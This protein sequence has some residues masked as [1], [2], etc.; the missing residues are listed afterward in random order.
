MER[1]KVEIPGI[2]DVEFDIGAESIAD[3]DKK[4]TEIKAKYTGKTAG[5][6]VVG[7]RQKLTKGQLEGT[8]LQPAS[9]PGPRGTPQ[10]TG[11]PAGY[12]PETSSGGLIAP[13]GIGV[14]GRTRPSMGA[15]AP[16][17][18]PAPRP[19]A[20]PRA[21]PFISSTGVERVEPQEMPELTQGQNVV[22][23]RR[24][25]GMGPAGRPEYTGKPAGYEP[26]TRGE[27][28]RDVDVDLGETAPEEPLPTVSAGAS[29]F[30]ASSAVDREI[31]VQNKAKAAGLGKYSVQTTTPDGRVIKTPQDMGQRT[32]ILPGGRRVVMD[33]PE[34][35]FP[36]REPDDQPWNFYGS[37]TGIPGG[38]VT[39]MEH[40]TF[41]DDQ[42]GF[43]EAA[44]LVTARG[45]AGIAKSMG[46]MPK[47]GAQIQDE[48]ARGAANVVGAVMGDTP[49]EAAARQQSFVEG[50]GTARRWL[51]PQHALLQAAG[52]KLASGAGQ[53]QDVLSQQPA[54]ELMDRTTRDMSLGQTITNPQA[55][56]MMAAEN[57]P[58]LAASYAAAT[59]A[60]AAAPMFMFGLEAGG[61]MDELD[62]ARA[63]G[64]DIPEQKYV[65]SAVGT[66]VVNMF[67]ENLGIK[68]VQGRLLKEHPALAAKIGKFAESFAGKSAEAILGEG[69]TEGLQEWTNML[70]SFFASEP[71]P[72]IDKV[73][74]FLSDSKNWERAGKAAAAGS[75]LGGMV[76][77]PRLAGDAIR[78]GK[79]AAKK[80][81][82]EAA[83]ARGVAPPE[84]T[85]E[86]AAEVTSAIGE[87]MA[88]Q[89]AQAPPVEEEPAAPAPPP[90]PG[91]EA[92]PAPE[93]AQDF[94]TPAAPPVAEEPVAPPPGQPERRTDEA[95]A[96]RVSELM[97]KRGNGDISPEE[98]DEL[99]GLLHGR[100][101]SEAR[102][103][104]VASKEAR[105]HPISDLPNVRAF[106]EAVKA[107][108][109]TG[110]VATD[111]RGFKA[112]NDKHGQGAGNQI[113]RQAAKVM[114]DFAKQWG[115]EAYGIGG[116][117]VTIGLSGGTDRAAF[118]EA[119]EGHLADQGI[120]VVGQDGRT[121][122]YRGI[123]IKLLGGDDATVND[124]LKTEGRSTALSW[125]VEEEARTGAPDAGDVAG[126]APPVAGGTGAHPGDVGGGTP[127]VPAEEEVAPA[128]PKVYSAD[129]SDTERD[130]VEEAVGKSGADAPRLRGGILEGQSG[131]GWQAVLDALKGKADTLPGK[132]GR[133]AAK[134]RKKLMEAYGAGPV[135]ARQVE[136]APAAAPPE[137][138]AA[139]YGTPASPNV[140]AI[141]DALVAKHKKGIKFRLRKA[142]IAEV[143][144]LVGGKI[145]TSTP[146]IRAVDE[147]VELARV[148]R[149]REVFQE[150][151]NAGDS[152][153]AILEK[154]NR[155][156]EDFPASEAR[157]SESKAGQEFSTPTPLAFVVSRLAG[158]TSDS[159]VLDNSAGNGAMFVAT[160][161]NHA[162][163]V[164]LSETRAEHLRSQGIAVNEGDGRSTT[165]PPYPAG[166]ETD[167]VLINPP[168]GAAEQK[169]QKL[170]YELALAAVE[171][172]KVGGTLGLIV[173]GPHPS[174]LGNDDARAAHYK[175]L[176]TQGL[177][178]QLA[179][180]GVKVERVFTVSGKIYERSGTTY[181]VDVIVGRKMDGP[182]E[183]W[184]AFLNLPPVVKTEKELADVLRVKT[185]GATW[186]RPGDI[187]RPRAGFGE[188]PSDKAVPPPSD[189]DDGR[190]GGKGPADR[191]G[192]DR[193]AGPGDRGGRGGED[194]GGVGRGPERQSGEGDLAGAGPRVGGVNPP[195]GPRDG[196]DAGQGPAGSQPDVRGE[197]SRGE[198]ERE[199]PGAGGLGPADT[200]RPGPGVRG[201]LDPEA[202]RRIKE[203]LSKK[204][205][206]GLPIRRGRGAVGLPAMD[207]SA[208]L[209]AVNNLVEVAGILQSQ[210][211]GVSFEE[212]ISALREF[213]VDPDVA[214]FAAV[215]YADAYDAATPEQQAQMTDPDTGMEEWTGEK[216]R[217]F[218][219]EKPAAPEQKPEE[220][221]SER[222]KKEVTV[223]KETQEE[224][225]I[226]LQTPNTPTSKR[227]SIGSL[228]PKSLAEATANALKAV[229]EAHGPI[230][231]FVREELGFSKEEFYDKG[232]LS[233]EQVDALGLAL[234]QFKQGRGFILADQ[235]GIGKGRVV[236][237]ILVWA[238]K[239][240]NLPMFLTEKSKLYADM[241]RDLKAIGFPQHEPLITDNN[242]DVEIDPASKRKFI[243]NGSEHQA[244]LAEAVQNYVEK[245]K[246]KGKTGAGASTL[247][248]SLFSTYN[249]ITGPSGS[250]RFQMLEQVAFGSVVVL[251]ES[252][253][254][255]GGN[256]A[257]AQSQQ[258]GK[259]GKGTPEHRG[260]RIAAIIG[261]AKAVLFSSA[262]FA[263]R[264]DSLI[265]YA[266]FTDAGRMKMNPQELADTIADGGVPLQQALSHMLVE[267]GQMIRREKSFAG[268][269]F[270]VEVA[271]ADKETSERISQAT[272]DLYDID[273]MMDEY[274]KGINAE[275]AGETGRQGGVG[276]KQADRTVFSSLFNNLIGQ[277]L[278]ALKV[279]IVVAKIKAIHDAGDSPFVTFSSTMEFLL[280]E[281]PAAAKVDSDEDT[282]V[283]I[284][285]ADNLKRY[286]Q[287]IITIRTK[288]AIPGG[289]PDLHTLTDDELEEIDPALLAAVEAIRKQLATDEVLLSIPGSPL[290]AVRYELE[291]YGLKVAEATGR[292]SK[293]EYDSDDYRS[294]RIVSRAAEKTVQAQIDMVAGY[295][296]RKGKVGERHV[297]KVDVIIANQSASTGIS[298]HN[299]PDTG[300]NRRRRHMVIVSPE[301]NI[302]TYMQMLGRINRTG[303]LTDPESLPTY[304]LF[305]SDLPLEVRQAAVL[306][307]KMA[308]LSANTTGSRTNV[309]S[310]K[311]PD[312][313]NQVG[314]GVMMDLL[315]ERQDINRKLGKPLKPPQQGQ[316]PSSKGLAAKATARVILLPVNEQAEF[317]D[318]LKERYEARIEELDNAGENPLVAK[319]IDLQAE[320]V[321]SAEVDPKEEGFSGPFAESVRIGVYKTLDEFK[322]LTDEEL[323]GQ[324]RETLASTEPEPPKLGETTE[325]PVRLPKEAKLKT[326]EQL[327]NELVDAFDK[328]LEKRKAELEDN[329]RKGAKE[330]AAPEE[331]ADRIATQL[332]DADLKAATMRTLLRQRR[333]GD[334]LSVSVGGQQASGVITKVEYKNK[335]ANP[336][337]ASN[338]RYSIALTDMH[339]VLHVSAASLGSTNSKTVLTNLGGANHKTGEAAIEA[340]VKFMKDRHTGITRRTRVIF[341]GNVMK[342]YARAK[343]AHGHM[344]R[345]TMKD[346]TTR[347]GVL[348]PRNFDPNKY[349]DDAPVILT[350]VN[351][352]IEW[353]RRSGKPLTSL[354]DATPLSD[355]RIKN[356]W[357][358]YVLSASR[359]GT[360]T[361]S[362]VLTALRLA[363]GDPSAG[364]VK[365]T[366]GGRSE[367]N[368]GK[369]ENVKAFLEALATSGLSVRYEITEMKAL[370]REIAGMPPIET[371]QRE[372]PTII[373][374]KEI[375]EFAEVVAEFAKGG[376]SLSEYQAT[377]SL[378]DPEVGGEPGLLNGITFSLRSNTRTTGTNKAAIVFLEPRPAQLEILKAIPGATELPS[379]WGSKNVMLPIEDVKAW[380][381]SYFE[382]RI[383][384]KY[385]PEAHGSTPSLKLEFE[386]SS[387]QALRR[388]M[389]NQD[390]GGV[391]GLA[392]KAKG[393]TSTGGT[394]GPLSP[395][396][397]RSQRLGGPSN[398]PKL[399][400]TDDTLTPDEQRTAPTRKQEILKRIQIMA[401]NPIRAGLGAFKRRKSLGWYMPRESQFRMAT[402]QKT[403]KGW[404]AV[405]G[406][407]GAL[408]V[409]DIMNM[410]VAAHEAGHSFHDRF[411]EGG[412]LTA[413]N[414]SIPQKVAA[415]L[416]ALGLECYGSAGLALK[417]DRLAAEG[418]AELFSRNL[419]GM[420]TNA[421]PVATDWFFN[422]VLGPR[423]EMEVIY[424]ETAELIRQY[425]EQGSFNRV[426]AHIDLKPRTIQQ[427]LQKELK[428]LHELV[429]IVIDK[430]FSGV[431]KHFVDDAHYLNKMIEDILAMSG[432]Q[433]R[434]LLIS[435]DPYRLRQA[436]EMVAPAM[437]QYAVETA[438]IGIDGTERSKGLK[439]ILKEIEEKYDLT[440]FMVYAVA[441]RA[442]LLHA[443][444]MQSGLS[445][446][447]IH[448]VISNV[449]AQ[450]P[451]KTKA[452][453]DAVVGVTEWSNAIMFQ[454]VEAG[455]MSQEAYDKILLFNPVYVPFK[456]VFDAEIGNYRRGGT[457]SGGRGIV[458]R[459]S[460]VK[461][462]HGS[463]K[464][465]RDPMNEFIRG[466]EQMLEFR[467]QCLIAQAALRFAEKV[468]WAAR[469]IQ[470]VTKME[471]KARFPLEDIKGALKEAGATKE[472][473]DNLD[474]DT[475][476]ELWAPATWNRDKTRNVFR[477]YVKGKPKLFEI[478]DSVADV[479]NGAV[480]SGGEK[481]LG[482]YHA[483][484]IKKVFAKSVRM[485]ATA[486]S[487]SF[488][489]RN[490]FRDAFNASVATQWGPKR[491]NDMLKLLDV[492]FSMHAEGAYHMLKN[493]QYGAMYKAF[494]GGMSTLQ[495]SN[496]AVL[497][498]YTR[499]AFKF[500]R[501]KKEAMAERALHPL[502][503]AGMG[504]DVVSDVLGVFESMP[505]VAE[506]RKAFQAAKDRN[507]NDR[508]AYLEALL[509]SKD[510]TTNFTRM[511]VTSRA[512]NQYIPFFNARI[513]GADKFLRMFRDDPT[514]FN[515]NFKR[516]ALMS[517]LRLTAIGIVFWWFN[518]D[519]DEYQRL[520]AYE[521]DRFWIFP[522][523][524]FGRT[525]KIP[526]PDTLGAA[527][528]T[529][530]EKILDA[531]Y[532]TGDPEVQ[533]QIASVVGNILD[534]L[535][536]VQLPENLG[537]PLAYAK[538]QAELLP[539]GGKVL[540]EAGFNYSAFRKGQPLYPE[541][542]KSKKER[543]DWV[544]P[545]TTVTAQ[546][547][548]KAQVAVMN[549]LGLEK[550]IGTS[551]YQGMQLPPVILDHV[552]GSI[553]GGLGLDAMRGM[554]WVRRRMEG[555]EKNEPGDLSEL[556]GIG[557]AFQ[558]P[559]SSK[560]VDEVYEE[561]Q[562]LSQKKGSREL[563][564][565]EEDRLAEL[566]D[567]IETFREAKDTKPTTP[568]ERRAMAKEKNEVAVHALGWKLRSEKAEERKN[569]FLKGD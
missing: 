520:K 457:G 182:Q 193:G 567:A 504:L 256:S 422:R 428:P 366:R 406:V 104:D 464:A 479:F 141:A 313:V 339:R 364:F 433:R 243:N 350:D 262:T 452:Y 106:E 253:N 220:K 130:L 183:T 132:A 391:L 35:E 208:E 29:K 61:Q 206:Q 51:T 409:A 460:P 434:D 98:T 405:K 333:M 426:L 192:R 90:E 514:R 539:V 403:R 62:A 487:V 47:L 427:W 198:G 244:L 491:G 506:F 251:D 310:F 173:G 138:P 282:E 400:A 180:A 89:R 557:W 503:T 200:G 336:W 290:D 9:A 283:D 373:G 246:L 516:L 372:S 564:A 441:M 241:M 131:D 322:Q 22:A 517:A 430:V 394:Q 233:G 176:T 431:Y 553:T 470:P 57:A 261:K 384:M 53:A 126:G 316:S 371:L 194:S 101:E 547:V 188:K 117:E 26:Q 498:R 461:A 529:I 254:A 383:G 508:D 413:K 368:L 402:D 473:F 156:S 152:D 443:R 447:D 6:V 502:Q 33:M 255:A 395:T 174:A 171:H 312:F 165:P 344:V 172:L 59:V 369:A 512:M 448:T 271:A 60:P 109:H 55:M 327:T 142:A 437:T 374:V 116:D 412:N 217:Q 242:F 258:R 356:A 144:T 169:G 451:A 15:P 494:G 207:A 205:P 210:L 474:L 218:F 525:M 522:A 509:A 496:Q 562:S 91:P 39:D 499:E 64:K 272:R 67:L 184:P 307:K 56:G 276:Q 362:M 396:Q 43:M 348:M 228:I 421:Y 121:Y 133:D 477:V 95:S 113:I 1:Y 14:P 12:E 270:N 284:T 418:F 81:F 11:K 521:R 19:A 190:E 219:A 223:A 481:M 227:P 453:A 393:K 140:P 315:Q 123:P 92:P 240:G 465:I 456:R 536:P 136:E 248:D 166:G 52:E 466:A 134:L 159:N 44:P 392:P 397:P 30:L 469:L 10:Y 320:E 295:N 398:A 388:N 458:D 317:Y 211:G 179:A 203:L 360:M 455:G 155:L 40:G 259:G 308:S 300:E 275:S 73:A 483:G 497:E 18:A 28:I 225:E 493:D 555:E 541:W 566:N 78:A 527:F 359:Q 269:D 358:K 543:A 340:A 299:S 325:M 191:G 432:S 226:E 471:L 526:K 279:P 390:T 410:A 335:L 531:L 511:G 94:G 551:L 54:V 288:S 122:R 20:P 326:P 280:K 492:P 357:H 519:D 250:R 80:K 3:L 274:V 204:K 337:M 45:A 154:L 462:I 319:T 66:G 87:A 137:A 70:S 568:A 178:A 41:A 423:P 510:V 563:S 181:P 263:K 309:A 245:Q 86:Q 214:V 281:D 143:E 445:D 545:G 301:A 505:R 380:L 147:A 224:G 532:H 175:N 232:P 286:L 82:I 96:A 4:I 287:K 201:K 436:L 490:V 292:N 365:A 480:K 65:L 386:L 97:T 486:L 467:N 459:A 341:T 353:L 158:V 239:N 363:M 560:A 74:A 83:R 128:A 378:V 482:M 463:T 237:G 93:S 36:G 114:Q 370:A 318:M 450:G 523:K 107:G 515:E 31:T 524:V 375:P 349:L 231:E 293:V 196:G 351:H 548:A 528:V 472:M 49:E 238:I 100:A 485:G 329:I 424:H 419:F 408:R 177:F 150:A 185:L 108:A 102:R 500:H 303:Q 501:S 84:V 542:K 289:E 354:G 268:I 145:D 306:M 260:K 266:P 88:A 533:N 559:E 265:I 221:K 291:K 489:V 278:M 162:A 476:A 518:K 79:D 148:L 75:M 361:D 247:F 429:D 69:G 46:M 71:N 38:P 346:G 285:F 311:M 495:A 305:T 213:D 37:N 484:G 367:A 77:G 119:L 149:S 163:A 115:G 345:F 387:S 304:T 442:K 195:V 48:A 468:P 411:L 199:R 404:T 16:A 120:V 216:L 68:G 420:D 415:E 110:F 401:G 164:E 129:I 235:T 331:I 229:E 416:R 475:L 222:K 376:G 99:I 209:E 267:S 230:D 554:D 50:V 338:V 212:F 153:G 72:D 215:A 23:Q 382:Q 273:R 13:A 105:T 189:A 63:Q 534:A 139:A 277:A 34:S 160:P 5:Q 550:H 103:A 324:L 252:H 556:P 112:L 342:A 438:V 440:E 21:N 125:R 314:D 296:G 17:P 513:Q 27:Q 264:P 330:D 561:Q 454:I 439:P 42:T 535:A 352:V 446:S 544:Q 298:A 530:P 186:D 167:V 332:A 546:R 381:E 234:H 157:T 507:M 435:E 488:T 236:A 407:S 478:D 417:P 444:G 425:D 552:I 414:P 389:H 161:Q 197:E 118:E 399:W 321:S 111:L 24:A 549:A 565:D 202:Q 146:A 347:Q 538:V 2:D 7:E 76:A 257:G 151:E 85:P 124:R 135:D 377:G 343:D 323:T 168:F 328:D 58:Q 379:T 537:D 32:A 355:L 297:P 569:R 127:D 449:E 249:Q 334:I 294:G 385:D 302:D 170:E 8:E 187:R 540:L 25:Q 558:R